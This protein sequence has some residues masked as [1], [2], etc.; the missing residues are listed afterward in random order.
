MRCESRFAQQE[1]PINNHCSSQQPLQ[2]ARLSATESSARRHSPTSEREVPRADGHLQSSPWEGRRCL[3][4]QK[5]WVT[6]RSSALSLSIKAPLPVQQ[7]CHTDKHL[8]LQDNSPARAVHGAAVRSD[9]KVLRDGKCCTNAAC[10][11]R[12][13]LLFTRPGSRFRFQ[14]KR[15]PSGAP[16]RWSGVSTSH[17]ESPTRGSAG[18][19]HRHRMGGVVFEQALGQVPGALSS[20]GG[21]LTSTTR[22]STAPLVVGPFCKLPTFEAPPLQ[23]LL[24]RV[25]ILPANV[26]RLLYNEIGLSQHFF[27]VENAGEHSVIKADITAPIAEKQSLQVLD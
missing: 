22:L 16:G 5:C 23:P 26:F 4:T 24:E 9:C 1:L 14:V 20:A 7:C 12:R 3:D 18:S 10:V 19:Q 11:S 6:S 13:P 15:S 27:F 8:Y 21:Q 25:K 17:L 2:T